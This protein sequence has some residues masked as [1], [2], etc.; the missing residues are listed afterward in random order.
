M[1]EKAVETA[2]NMLTK[3]VGTLE[4][5]AEITG[6]SLEQAQELQKQLAADPNAPLEKLVEAVAELAEEY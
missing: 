5:I 2:R 4:Q 6:L 1:E 3:K